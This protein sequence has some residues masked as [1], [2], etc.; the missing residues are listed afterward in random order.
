M[1]KAVVIQ[2]LVV[3]VTLMLVSPV[4]RTSA[5]NGT[6]TKSR[7]INVAEDAYVV[8]YLNDVNDVQDL[9]E[10][11]YGSLDFVKTWY[12]WNVGE[13]GGREVESEK[14]ISAI[15]LKFD[16]GAVQDKK[17]ESAMLQLYARDVSL[18][19]PRIVQVF[20][21]S[22]DWS[23]ST[24]NFTSRPA[25]GTSAVASTIVYR[26]NHW[27][28]WDVTDQ[29][30]REKRP[31]QIS[32]VVVLRDMEPG[33]EE[34][35]AFYSRE[36]QAKVPRLVVTYTEA[37]IAIPWSWWCIG[38]IVIAAIATV[39]FFAGLKCKSSAKMGQF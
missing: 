25:W 24:I 4:L 20:P 18:V 38:G 2:F 16:L 39:A 19:S 13:E 23:E 29:V 32:F 27:Y 21:V 1:R 8:A 14:I 3:L 36:A 12:L 30:T 10:R 15:Y 33:M 11:N 31:E 17:I 9:R 37:E 7:I 35:V 34:L 22:S 5:G 6:V 26:S 28:A